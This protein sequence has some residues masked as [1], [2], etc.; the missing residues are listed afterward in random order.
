MPNACRYFE[1]G[2]VSHQRLLIEVELLKQLHEA[3][4][5]RDLAWT[6]YDTPA[7]CHFVQAGVKEAED[8]LV[9]RFPPRL[10]NFEHRHFVQQYLQHQNISPS[11]EETSS[12]RKL[13]L[14]LIFNVAIVVAGLSFALGLIVYDY[15]H[16]PGHLLRPL[17]FPLT[18]KRRRL[19]FSD[20]L[21][22]VLLTF[23]GCILL[24]CVISATRFSR[25]IMIFAAVA[26]AAIAALLISKTYRVMTFLL[27]Y[28]ERRWPGLYDYLN[29]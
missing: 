29:S 26:A 7:L 24:G 12:R 8:E 19:S 9:Q 18:T 16:R 6:S 23:A 27:K 20:D 11:I 1:S 22:I 28:R 5:L 10:E 2:E 4:L 15:I 14:L 17:D 25:T 21:P 3:D 13:P